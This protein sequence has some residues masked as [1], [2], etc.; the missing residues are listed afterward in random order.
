MMLISRYQQKFQNFE[1]NDHAEDIRKNFSAQNIREIEEHIGHPLPDDYADF[2][3]HYG[4]SWFYST[5]YPF[6]VPYLNG[7]Q[8]SLETVFGIR[9]PGRESDELLYELN[10]RGELMPSNL[11]PISD[12][13]GCNLICISLYG[14]DQGHVYFWFGEDGEMADEG[15]EPGYSNLAFIA[16]SFDEFVNSFTIVEN[17]NE[18]YP[19]N[20]HK[21]P[22]DDVAMELK[23]HFNAA[24]PTSRYQ[25]KIQKLALIDLT[26]EIRATFSQ[27]DIEAIET[28]MGYPLPDIYID[29]LIHFGGM[30]TCANFLLHHG[31]FELIMRPSIILGIQVPEHPQYELLYNI[32]S[33]KPRNLPNLLPIA[34]CA[35]GEK[36]CLS[37]AGADQGHIYL[38]EPEDVPMF[39]DIKIPDYDD[40]IYRVADSL[41]EFVDSLY[42]TYYAPR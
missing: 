9:V 23:T 25:S 22:L 6:P 33:L 28:M 3:I 39:S 16:S 17:A 27:Q 38:W 1:W 35:F 34:R 14:V 15:E 18:S 8:G 40:N 32:N 5:Y 19:T 41:D 36:L 2:L 21:R 20:S 42:I 30:G 31:G 13:L 4:G 26:G 10:N 7:E 29:F 24:Y 11:L 12:G 37:L